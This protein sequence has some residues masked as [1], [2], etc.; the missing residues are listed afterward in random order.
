MTIQFSCLRQQNP[1]TCSI[2]RKAFEH[3]AKN[4]EFL[5]EA[6][7]LSKGCTHIVGERLTRGFAKGISVRPETIEFIKKFLSEKI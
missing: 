4:P 6:D 5:K 1:N 7:R 3:M 2:M